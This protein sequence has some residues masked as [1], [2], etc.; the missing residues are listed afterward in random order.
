MAYNFIQFQHD[1]SLPKFIQCFGTEGACIE[2]LQR[3]RWP[4]GL[5]CPRCGGSAH[6]IVGSGSRRRFQCNACHVQTSMTAGT[7]FASTKLPQ[8]TWFLAIFLLSQAKPRPVCRHWRQSAR[9]A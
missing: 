5:V 4:A 2:A 7:L 9:L 8:T 6:C 1:M 3:A